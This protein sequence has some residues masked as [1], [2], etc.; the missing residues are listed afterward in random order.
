M[1]HEDVSA[2]AAV[3]DKLVVAPQRPQIRLDR[4]SASDFDRGRA[5]LVEALWRAFQ[6]LLF[7]SPLPG[8][9]LRTMLLRWFGARIGTG[10][11][12]KPGCRITFPWRLEM[13]DHVWIGERVWIDNLGEV[14][15]DSHA[16]LSQGAYLCTGSHDWS[17]P[18]FDLIVRPIVVEA[19]AWL[20]AHCRVGPGVT[21]G[22]GA[23]LALASTTTRDLEPWTIYQGCPAKP[24][25][26]R[27]LRGACGACVKPDADTGLSGDERRPLAASST[28]D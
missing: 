14:R 20:A 9:R 28:S 11:V 19:G 12:I 26:R 13:G 18:G 2:P 15:I 7:S 3:A 1:P 24:V 23:V 17:S 4:Y 22:E 25:R 5:T 6:A 21:V 10:V 8:S 16:C 27:S